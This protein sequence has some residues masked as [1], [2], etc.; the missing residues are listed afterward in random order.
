MVEESSSRSGQDKERQDTT[1]HR[2]NA[3]LSLS[4]ACPSFPFLSFPFLPFLSLPSSQPNPILATSRHVPSVEHPA[5]ACMHRIHNMYRRVHTHSCGICD[6]GLH[7]YI[8]PYL[9]SQ[10]A[11]RDQRTR[12]EPRPD[13]PSVPREATV[14]TGGENSL[15]RRR[16]WGGGGKH[17]VSGAVFTPRTF[18]HTSL[19]AT[20]GRTRKE[21][22]STPFSTPPT[23]P[24][25][26]SEGIRR[27]ERERER[28]RENR[29][30]LRLRLCPRHR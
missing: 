27:K 6:A 21:K 11:Q 10:R 29:L 19:W 17:C 8:H 22:R 30:R 4:L 3:P 26:Q 13:P 15:G 16:R 25:T 28:E 20:E 14:Q 5:A 18:I 24:S 2:W 7:T 9:D 1:R 23:H 12:R